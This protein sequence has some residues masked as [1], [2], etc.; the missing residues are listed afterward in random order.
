LLPR[1][2]WEDPKM[3]CT[4]APVVRGELLLTKEATAI[5]SKVVQKGFRSSRIRNSSGVDVIELFF[6]VTRLS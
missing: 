5:K 3:L 2:K 4:V 1:P 6:F